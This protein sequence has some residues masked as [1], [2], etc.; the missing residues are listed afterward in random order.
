MPL[1][2]LR[3]G[4]GVL[5]V[6]WEVLPYKHAAAFALIPLAVYAA[7]PVSKPMVEVKTVTKFVDRW[8]NVMMPT[9]VRVRT[10][11]LKKPEPV[12]VEIAQQEEEMPPLVVE[13]PRRHKAISIRRRG[14]ICTRHNRRKV[15]YYKGR[16]RY[17][18]C[19]R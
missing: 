10:I 15:V 16:Y 6:L 7:V 4:W 5:R 13:R 14:D 12:T 19:V 17:W 2:V 3:E 11:S 9:E 1:D 8:P 18:R